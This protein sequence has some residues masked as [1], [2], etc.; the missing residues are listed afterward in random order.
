MLSYMGTLEVV[1]F[2]TPIL[3]I[4][5]L[6]QETSGLCAESPSDLACPQFA[7]NFDTL[8]HYVEGIWTSRMAY[9]NQK[10]IK[11]ISDP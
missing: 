8:V 1:Q 2:K 5:K 11:I 6:T 7:S 3:Q 4:R 9:G 10:K